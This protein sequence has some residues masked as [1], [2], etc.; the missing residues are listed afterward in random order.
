[1]SHL[2]TTII[3]KLVL[4]FLKNPRHF[5]KGKVYLPKAFGI[6]GL[7]CTF[8]P[9][10]ASIILIFFEEYFGLSIF[11]FIMAIGASSLIIGYINCR[12]CYDEGGFVVRTF[13]GREK[14][15]T[16]YDVTAIKVCAHETYIY[17]GNQR[18]MVDELHVGGKEFIEFVKMMYSVTHFNQPIPIKN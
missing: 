18:T 3:L 6:L 16:Y 5:E 10:I 12:I 11:F 2:G 15:F 8:I 7:I 9:L 14:S 1:M 4:D 13:F 17:M